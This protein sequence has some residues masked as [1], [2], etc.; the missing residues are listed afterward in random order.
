VRSEVARQAKEV[1]NLGKKILSLET[2][3]ADLERDKEKL[4]TDI[5]VKS[6]EVEEMQHQALVSKKELGIME[7]QKEGVELRLERSAQTIKNEAFKVKSADSARTEL[8]SQLLLLEECRNAETVLQHTKKQV[9]EGKA[10][11]KKQQNLYHSVRNDRA[12]LTR[13]VTESH[14]EVADLKEKMKVLTHQFDQLKE[15]IIAKEMDLVKESQEKARVLRDKDG[16]AKDIEKVK[17]DSKEADGQKSDSEKKVRRLEER[18]RK[19]ET[20]IAQ[21]HA[22]L[23]KSASQREVLNARLAIK[24]QEIEVLQ[25]KADVH[26]KVNER[27]EA[28]YNERMEDVRLLKLEIKRLKEE[29]AFLTNDTRNLGALKKEVLK[30]ERD[31]MQQKS[32]NKVLQLELENPLNVHRWRRLEGKDPETLELIQKINN[33]QRRLISKQEDLI[34]KDMKIEE[35]NKLYAES[36]IQI[37]RQPKY[38]VHDEIRNLREELRRK[39]DRILILTTESN[40]YQVET[41]KTKKILDGM[42]EELNTVKQKYLELRRQEQK[43]RDTLGKL[44]RQKSVPNLVPPE[45]AAEVEGGLPALR[46]KSA[47]ARVPGHLAKTKQGLATRG[48]Y[49]GGGFCLAV[50]LQPRY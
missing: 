2:V 39:N 38:D 36:K 42:N 12:Q 15:E 34:E 49:V 22:D 40:M 31:L 24:A 50:P 23:E 43:T 44:R 29:I 25:R 3:R 48:P 32:R 18:Q 46:A 17:V 37:S 20:E 19:L 1:E 45:D 16:L 26:R 35:I 21:S 47:G 6:R 13:A 10:E 28:N 41:S 33:L 8:Q 30:L 11:L 7:N 5:A 27:G 9:S 4:K 14:D